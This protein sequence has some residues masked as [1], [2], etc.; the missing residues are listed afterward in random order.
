MLIDKLPKEKSCQND[1]NFASGSPEQI[2]IQQSEKSKSFLSNRMKILNDNY[3]REIIEFFATDEE[4]SQKVEEFEFRISDVRVTQ[5]F[6]ILQIYYCCKNNTDEIVVY[7]QSI[8]GKV[9]ETLS[10]IMSKRVPWIQ[11]VY[12]LQALYDEEIQTKLEQIRKEAKDCENKIDQ[13]IFDDKNLSLDDKI[14]FT[15]TIDIN[16][17]ENLDKLK[18]KT[19]SNR[20]QELNLPC[21]DAAIENSKLD[22]EYL[23]KKVLLN[24]HR[25]RPQHASDMSIMRQIDHIE[26]NNSN[27][28]SFSP[29]NYSQQSSIDYNTEE[30]IK[31]IKRFVMLSR[32]QK[33]R[34]ERKLKHKLISEELDKFDNYEQLRMH[35][36]QKHSVFHNED[37]FDSYRFD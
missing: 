18:W 16:V 10:S 22:Y 34:F 23:F 15:G 26:T 28:Q 17:E 35:L 12:D 32:K 29:D 7:L 9:Y 13:Y 1:F 30:R 19:D 36:E 11:F 33:N 31:S 14:N 20:F 6:S 24:M 2:V 37:Q 8:K 21:Y 3:T 5:D 25:T 4:V 27:D